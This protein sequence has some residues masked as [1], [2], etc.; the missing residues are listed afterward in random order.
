MAAAINC[1][2]NMKS[3]P[4]PVLIAAAAA[5]I[6]LP[7]S[8]PAA[9]TLIFTA[10]LGSIIHTDYVCR[11]QRLRLPKLA[12]PHIRRTHAPF[13]REPNRLAA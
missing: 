5:I 3:F 2:L 4:P 11:R 6:A 10:A 9:G 7:F 8:I 12:V 1:I 13:Y